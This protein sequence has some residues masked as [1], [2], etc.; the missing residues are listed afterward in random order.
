MHRK[1]LVP[2]DFILAPPGR[3]ARLRSHAK[4][5]RRREAGSD[6]GPRP[7]VGGSPEG[8]S[9]PLGPLRVARS[10]DGGGGC[11]GGLGRWSGRQG[12]AHAPSVF[13]RNPL[14]P[15]CAGAAVR[16]GSEAPAGPQRLG[17]SHGSGRGERGVDPRRMSPSVRGL[18]Q[19]LG[20]CG[21]GFTSR[22]S[23]SAVGNRMRAWSGHPGRV[24]A[25]KGLPWRTAV[26]ASWR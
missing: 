22:S 14:L 26:D 25:S 1:F 9:G 12:R 2:L 21:G 18:P 24:A 3:W 17:R 8:H 20:S 13:R 6:E 15:P 5:S 7:V 23:P 19:V 11:S 4:A 10:G 16:R